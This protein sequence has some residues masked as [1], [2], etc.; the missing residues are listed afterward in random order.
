ML[1]LPVTFIRML[2]SDNPESP[3]SKLPDLSKKQL[4]LFYDRLV[5]RSQ[6]AKPKE[7]AKIKAGLLAFKKALG[8]ADTIN[9]P[10]SENTMQD[11]SPSEKGRAT[12]PQGSKTLN[13]AP[14]YADTLDM[15]EVIEEA[16][17]LIDSLINE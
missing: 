12:Q 3:F 5:Q 9:E 6:E 7:N 17:K 14:V 15:K 11:F 2:K 13:R 16:N 1:Y 4:G 8:T 10:G